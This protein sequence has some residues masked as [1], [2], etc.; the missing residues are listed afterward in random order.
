MSIYLLEER[1]SSVCP[2]ERLRSQL[3]AA[4]EPSP[5][6]P[7]VTLPQALLAAVDVVAERAEG[8]AILEDLADRAAD[9]IAAWALDWG[10]ADD[11][12]SDDIADWLASE[13]AISTTIILVN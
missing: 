4:L 10:L 5:A 6:K 9:A 11:V 1:A 3:R 2:L 13:P 8:S 12:V 7:P